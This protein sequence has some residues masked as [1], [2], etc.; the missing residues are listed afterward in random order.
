MIGLKNVTD[1]D[2]ANA[3]DVYNPT[4][5]LLTEG[6]QNFVYSPKQQLEFGT[7]KIQPGETWYTPYYVLVSQD[8]G[9][10][11]L[12]ASYIKRTA[13]RTKTRRRTRS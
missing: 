2:P 12:N 8:T 11:D 9:I 4:V 1:S 6:T 5:E 13:G 7:A 3:T 10:L